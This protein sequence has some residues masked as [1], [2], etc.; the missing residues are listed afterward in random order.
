[1]ATD[2][3]PQLTLKFHQKI[4]PVVARFDAEHAST[5]GGALLL[6]AM[7]EPPVSGKMSCGFFQNLGVRDERVQWK[8]VRNIHKSLKRPL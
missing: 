4:K 7:D 1:M 3:I 6:K 5:D 8:C 2:C